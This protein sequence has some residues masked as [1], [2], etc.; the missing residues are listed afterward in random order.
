VIRA[1][2]GWLPI[3]LG[4]GWLVGELTGCGR[5]AAT[6]DPSVDPLVLLIQGAALVA[7]LL[8]PLA[9]SLAAGAAIGL[10]VAAVAATLVLSATGTA[11]DEGSRRATL[12]LLLLVAW[13]AGLT[14]A[15][16]QRARSAASRV[17]PVS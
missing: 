5:F 8:L 14:I 9:A 17:G 2:V 7:L 4:L 12:G 6:C 3:A 15:I 1:L 16:V 10:V 13:L 11:A